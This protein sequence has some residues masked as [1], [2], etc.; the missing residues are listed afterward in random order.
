MNKKILL[1]AA[2]AVTASQTAAAAV[3]GTPLAEAVKSLGPTD[4]KCHLSACYQGGLY[5]LGATDSKTSMVYHYWKDKD[6]S[7]SGSRAIALR[8]VRSDAKLIK[9]K[10]VDNGTVVELYRSPQLA[11]PFSA[12]SD[13][14]ADAPAGTFTAMHSPGGRKTI[15][16]L[17]QQD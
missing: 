3:L 10:T 8:M 9:S 6:F 14:W 2:F 16:S 15:V 12:K 11:K 7:L 4:E 1:L 17:G 5:A 13:V